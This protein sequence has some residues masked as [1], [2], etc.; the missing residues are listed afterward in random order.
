VKTHQAIAPNP[1]TKKTREDDNNQGMIFKD[2]LEFTCQFSPNFT[3]TAANQ[4]CCRYFGVRHADLLGQNFMVL[5]PESNRPRLRRHLQALNPEHPTTIFEQCT[6]CASGKAQCQEWVIQA[7]FNGSAVIDRFVASGRDVTRDILTERDLDKSERQYRSV[8][9]D[10]V[11]LVCRYRPDGKITFANEAYCRNH[12]KEPDEIIGKSFLPY[13]Q[14]EDREEISK[15]INSADPDHPV[16]TITQQITNSSGDTIWVEWCRRALFDN[17]GQLYEIQGVGRDIT[18]FKKAQV[19]LEFS[20]EALRK[21]NIEMERKNAA[22]TEVLAQI[23]HQKQQIKE[24]VTANVEELL[25]PMIEQLIS[26]KLRIEAKHLILIKQ[27]LQDLTSSFGR[28]ITRKSLKLTSREIQISN[29]IKRGLSSKEIASLC[30]ISPYTV[31]RH[32]QSIRKKA[33]ISN[34]H[35]N[36][37]TF[38]LNM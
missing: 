6:S 3:L 15:F 18:E 34:K 11:E 4:T 5:I 14:P 33:N 24:D 13:I 21:K 26:K 28:K 9:E 27:S 7:V 35:I 22:L 16:V 20:K 36:L 29:M 31:A 32:R 8:V 37:R 17:A 2:Q 12:G 19:D 10:Q 25:M 30:K 38:L 23:E 1:A